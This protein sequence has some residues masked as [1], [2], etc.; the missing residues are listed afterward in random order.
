MQAD[1]L[2]IGDRYGRFRVT[3]VAEMTNNRIA[4]RFQDEHGETTQNVFDAYELFSSIEP[5]ATRPHRR[6]WA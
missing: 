1:D 4:V 3:G 2:R 6:S 5:S